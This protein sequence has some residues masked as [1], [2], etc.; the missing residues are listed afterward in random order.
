M[1]IRVSQASTTRF[2]VQ[3]L[4]AAYRQQS[5]VKEKQAKVVRNNIRKKFGFLLSMNQTRIINREVQASQITIKSWIQK[6]PALFHYL[7]TQDNYCYH[8]IFYENEKSK[9]GQ[10]IYRGHF[11]TKHIFLHKTHYFLYTKQIFVH[12]THY[13]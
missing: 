9:K 7:R 6:L 1:Y 3:G 2:N 12:K 10:N 5:P 8:E 4:V 11:H 13:V